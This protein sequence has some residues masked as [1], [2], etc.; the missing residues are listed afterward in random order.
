MGSCLT[1]HQTIV[2][3]QGAV[4]ATKMTKPAQ[5]P[6]KAPMIMKSYLSHQSTLPKLPVPPLQQTLYKYLLAVQPLLS[7]DEYTNTK[8]IVDEFGK[9]GG[10]GERLQM[11]LW[12][13]AQKTESWLSE[14]WLHAAYLD[15]RSPVVVNS[16]PGV[17]FPLQDFADQKEQLRFASKLIAGVLDYKVMVD[18][19]NLPIDMMGGQPLCMDQYYKILSSCR[20]PGPKRDS[21]V[22]YPGN[23]ANAPKHII[24][25]H[26]N[27]FFTLDVYYPSGKPLGIDE[28]FA[29]LEKIINM[30]PKRARPVGILTTEHRNTWGKVYRKLRKFDKANK[31][32]LEAIERSIFVLCLDEHTDNV[33]IDQRLSGLACQVLHGGGSA[34]NSGNRWADKT[35]QFII[36]REGNCGIS[37]EHAPAEGPPVTSLLDHSLTFVEKVGNVP[38]SAPINLPDP[39]RL[40]FKVNDELLQDIEIA[41]RH[42]DTMVDELQVHAFQFQPFGK[43]IPKANRMSPDAFIQVA[44]QL[45]YYRIYSQPTAT[46]ES[47]SLRRYRLGRTDTIR[48]CTTDS[49]N[50]CKAM[51]NDKKTPSEKY[52][53]LRKAVEAHKTY[54]NEALFGDVIDRHLLGLKLTAIESGLNVPEIFMDP[55]YQTAMHFKLST[56]QVPSKFDLVMCFGPVVP[57]GY[58][59]CYN[60]RETHINFVLSAFNTSPE[61]DAQKLAISLAASLMEMQQ[62]T[63]QNEGSKL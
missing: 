18:S 57:D 58:G 9:P 25:I 44:L 60:P 62:L 7:E 14:W 28:L 33:S 29:Q 63:I 24:V 48:S 6:T 13:R 49:V 61:T 43:N 59:V 51:L 55:A 42:L 16:S 11:K 10:L 22:V 40:E 38:Q 3:K 2:F 39:K 12:Q 37:Y 35:L 26:N 5:A 4:A 41:E 8:Q 27:H 19:E 54:T 50:F 31:K 46:Y 23:K 36:G 53:L 34:K 17:A 32:I 45:A 52:R 20:I 56:S 30:S 21:V 47:A 1:T 15:F